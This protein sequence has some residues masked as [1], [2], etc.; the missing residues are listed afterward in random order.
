MTSPNSD[1]RP[2]PDHRSRQEW[3]ANPE[4]GPAFVLGSLER[5]ADIVDSLFR[6]IHSVAV[7]FAAVLESPHPSGR[8]RLCLIRGDLLVKEPKY[9]RQHRVE[10]M[11]CKLTVQ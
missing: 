2:A 10:T 4:L 11:T 3:E 1:A 9:F 7:V 5:S 8:C 6:N